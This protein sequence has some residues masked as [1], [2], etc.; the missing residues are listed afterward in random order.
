M[1]KRAIND[2]ALV[3][4]AITLLAALSVAALHRNQQAQVTEASVP[5]CYTLHCHAMNPGHWM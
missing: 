2:I 3:I 5:P 4:F 1:H